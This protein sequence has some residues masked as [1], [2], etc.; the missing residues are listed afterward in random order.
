[1]PP[2]SSLFQVIGSL[3]HS[4]NLLFE[5]LVTYAIHS[6]LLIGGLQLLTATPFGRRAFGNG[7]WLWRFALVGG[8][9]TASLQSLR[10]ASPLTGTL[11]LDEDTPART[12]V[13]VEVQREAP[14]MAT[15][16]GGSRTVRSSIDISPA[17]PLAV[18]AAWFV[19]AG[20]LL[21]WFVIARN[22]F[23]RSIGPR[24][25]G[26][27]TLAGNALRYLLRE[28]GLRRH[29]HLTISD[30]L[31]SPIAL[32][33]DEIC[34][35]AR[36]LAELDP[37]RMEG[38]L[39]H[40][41]AHLVRRDSTWLTAARVIEAIFFFQ[42]L[43]V[44]ARRRMQESAEF[45]SD[46]WASTRT[47]RPLDLAHCLARVAEWTIASPRLPVPAMAERRGPVLVRR[48]ERLTRGQVIPEQAPSR[49]TRLAAVVALAGL[50]LLAPKVA[51]GADGPQ[52]VFFNARLPGHGGV[53]LI[54]ELDSTVTTGLRGR[55]AK[56]IVMTRVSAERN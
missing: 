11:R 44:I 22:R 25:S 7:S 6:T 9:I 41:L 1:M 2:V 4:A 49:G 56:A 15:G 21:C 45:A 29:V 19:I 12:M 50:V 16:F 51:V 40:E 32:G 39:A 8:L 10:S 35:P 5:W 34:L 20:G 23:L 3:V 55:T 26:D 27:H 46:A 48:V 47:A 37:I 14:G 30:R 43:N 42:P 28:G 52:N 17:W 36:A 31:T 13:R 24:H 38:M 18:L 33:S 53:V 54:R